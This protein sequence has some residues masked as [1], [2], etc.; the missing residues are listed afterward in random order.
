MIH[1][2]DET[3]A[4]SEDALKAN[5]RAMRKAAGLSQRDLADRLGTS[6]TSIAYMETLS[7]PDQTRRPRIDLTHAWARECGFV[8]SLSFRRAAPME[9]E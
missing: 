6:K 4:F 9:A 7:D 1:P 3:G 2:Y 5:L 8:A